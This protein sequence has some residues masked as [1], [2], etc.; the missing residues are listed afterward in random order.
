M[1]LADGCPNGLVEGT[2]VTG[3]SEVGVSSDIGAWL[4]GLFGAGPPEFVGAWLVGISVVGPDGDAK[5]SGDGLAV[6]TLILGK[7]DVDPG[8]EVTRL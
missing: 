1:G 6:T 5:G 2:R 4:V 7:S 8:L 3:A